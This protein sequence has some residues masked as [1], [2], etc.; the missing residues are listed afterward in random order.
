M[1]AV[2]HGFQEQRTD[3]HPKPGRRDQPRR[4]HAGPKNDPG[5]L[6]DGLWPRCIAAAARPVQLERMAGDCVHAFVRGRLS[7]FLPPPLRRGTG[8]RATC[9][10]F[11]TKRTTRAQHWLA[12]TRGLGLALEG[13]AH[14]HVACVPARTGEDAA[15]IA[16]HIWVHA[17]F[18][19]VQYE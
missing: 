5:R 1:E 15:L 19:H 10:S 12:A 11:W 13:A 7:L 8:R 17:F 9:P 6:Y 16:S 2:E 14:A 18:I 3:R 4:R